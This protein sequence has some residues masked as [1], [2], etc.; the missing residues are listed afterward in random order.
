[1]RIRR[2]WLGAALALCLLS[3]PAS[4]QTASVPDAATLRT[5]EDQVADIRGLQP[6]S[7]PEPRLLDHTTLSKYLADQF[8]SNYL[9]GE[10]E[11]DQKELVALGLIQHSDDL[12]QIQLALLNE[13]VIGDYDSDTRSLF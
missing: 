10:R 6:L 4:A 9:P 1:M 5:I 2:A 12:V 8:A 11:S 13:Q 3:Q 7:F